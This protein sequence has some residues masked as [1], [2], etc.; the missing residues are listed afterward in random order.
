MIVFGGINLDGLLNTVLGVA[1]TG[2]NALNFYIFLFNNNPFFK[3][4]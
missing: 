4:Y 1:E 2:K 3:K